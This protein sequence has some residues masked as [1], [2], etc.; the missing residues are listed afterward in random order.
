MTSNEDRAT[1]LVRALRAGIEGD[2]EVL[3]A[4]FTDDVRAWTPAMSTTTLSELILEL[5]RRDEAFSDIVLDVTPLDVGGDHACAE[6]T[7]EMTHSG[8]VALGSEQIIEPSG[9]RVTLHGVTVAEFDG[10]RIC[11]LRQYWDEFAVLEQLGV[12]T[13]SE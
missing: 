9:I 8:S 4:V 5:D 1:T 7:V 12:L 10:D 6:W 3:H 2:Q 13:G 11:S